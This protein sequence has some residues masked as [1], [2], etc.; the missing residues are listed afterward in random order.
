[1]RS[2]ILSANQYV[3]AFITAA[4]AKANQ[5]PAV[6]A[7][8]SSTHISKAVNHA[9]RTIVFNRFIYFFSLLH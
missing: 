5:G 4:T 2:T 9:K 6:P 8:I 3:P 7:R 1:M